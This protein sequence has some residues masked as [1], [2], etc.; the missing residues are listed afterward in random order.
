MPPFDYPQSKEAPVRTGPLW[1]RDDP[2]YLAADFALHW[3]PVQQCFPFLAAQTFASLL[4]QQPPSDLQQSAEPS[5][6]QS[7]LPSLD[8]QQ[9]ALP[10]SCLA[11][12]AAVA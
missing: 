4:L 2:V 9:S 1:F 5:L 6:Q 12:Q 7:I 8:V 11:Q 10:F 3:P